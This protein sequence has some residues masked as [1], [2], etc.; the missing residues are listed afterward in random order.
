MIYYKVLL[1]FNLSFFCLFYWI[2]YFIWSFPTL[3][4]IL[5]HQWCMLIVVFSLWRVF[6][7]SSDVC[8]W[9]VFNFVWE[10]YSVSDNFFCFVFPFLDSMV[11]EIY[12]LWCIYFLFA[13]AMSTFSVDLEGA[14]KLM[15]RWAQLSIY[16]K[17]NVFKLKVVLF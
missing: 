11:C 4:G 7:Y 8:M 9:L 2:S 3:L 15:M 16:F 6:I 10:L 14:R 17:L 12:S 1:C 5:I 13:Y